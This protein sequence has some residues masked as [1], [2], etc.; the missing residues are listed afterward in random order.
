MITRFGRFWAGSIPLAQ[1][2]TCRSDFKR[3]DRAATLRQAA[4]RHSAARNLN[5]GPNGFNR[6][7]RGDRPDSPHP[8]RVVASVD[9][10]R[11]P[12]TTIETSQA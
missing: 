3:I 7:S 10:H 8:F 1:S 5:N 6:K 2:K 12:L 11:I 4:P 9:P